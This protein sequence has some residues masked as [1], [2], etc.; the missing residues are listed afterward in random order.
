MKKGR[1]IHTP[2]VGSNA[3]YR[4]GLSPPRILAEC[5]QEATEPG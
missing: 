2:R 5:H 1:E 3:L 4:I